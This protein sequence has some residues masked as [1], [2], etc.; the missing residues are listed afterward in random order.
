MR[1]QPPSGAIVGDSP[2]LWVLRFDAEGAATLVTE[3]GAPCLDAPEGGFCWVHLNVADLRF[4]DWVAAQ[5]ALPE[6]ARALLVEP[7]THQRLGVDG[8]ALWGVLPDRGRS[9]ERDDDVLRHLRIVMTERFVVTA[10]RRAVQSTAA[11]R[12]AALGGARFASPLDLVETLVEQTLAAMDAA[13]DVLFAEFN[14]IED[15]VL[16]DESRD[17][18]RRLG[19]LRRRTIR[20]HRDVA[21]AQR[22]FSRAEQ[23]ARVAEPTR[24][25]LRRISQRFDSLH[26]E[27]EALQA[28]ARLLQDEIVSNLT[29]E[30]NRQLYVLT[31]L[32]TLLMPPT[33]VS[34]IFGMNTK[35]L[36]FAENEHGTLYAALLCAASAAAALLALA[37][38]KRRVD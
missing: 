33:L 21:D 32:G 36:F 11:I 12:E 34:G 9:L 38:I 30:T 3:S 23:T 14:A 19:E 20:L 13:I 5:A 18:R 26:Q 8:G 27:L 25:A 35:N 24:A 1:L 29:A 10:R 4:R 17:E 6:E 15:R 2:F 7:D 37:W 28:R 16:D 31:I 22:V